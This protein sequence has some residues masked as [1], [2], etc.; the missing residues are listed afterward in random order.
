MHRN[1]FK[2]SLLALAA[3]S[4]AATHAQAGIIFSD[5][6]Y[7]AAAATTAEANFLSQA[8]SHI[9]ETFDD[10]GTYSMTGNA[11]SNF[12]SGDQNRWLAAADSFDTSVGTFSITQAEAGAGGDDVESSKLMLES[13]ATGEFGRQKNYDG[14]QWLDSNDADTVTWDFSTSSIMA[15]AFGFYLSDANDQGASLRLIFDDG[16]EHIEQLDSDLQN[17]NLMYA[18][19]ISDALINSATLIFDNGTFNN[20]GWGI[21]TITV[22]QVPEP[23]TL[24]LLGLGLAGL[25]FARRRST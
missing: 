23:G 15:N 24:A 5:I 10:S 11:G 12:G 16:S 20:D 22:A 13:S 18:T 9:T 8:S 17:G 7:G 21:D 14:G 25:T 4:L 2:R 1:T 6:A 19:F 3:A